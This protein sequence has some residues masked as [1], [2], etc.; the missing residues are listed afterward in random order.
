MPS[1][2]TFI[3]YCSQWLPP[4]SISYL[5]GGGGGNLRPHDWNHLMAHITYLKRVQ[6]LVTLL[7]R[8]TCHGSYEESLWK[9]NR[10]SKLA[11]S[12]PSNFKVAVDLNLFDSSWES[13]PTEYCKGQGAFDGEAV[14]FLCMLWDTE[15]K[16]QL[17]LPC[18]PH[19]TSLRRNFDHLWF[20][21]DIYSYISELPH[22]FVCVGLL[23]HKA[24]RAGYPTQI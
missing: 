1:S 17:P 7:V 18:H 15:I 16:C 12:W 9:I 20:E 2:N 11:P 14:R 5:D 22:S 13:T 19:F 6:R 23:F 3:N 10:F 24:Y 8:W 21:H 4:F